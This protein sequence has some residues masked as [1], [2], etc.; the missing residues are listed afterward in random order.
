MK[1]ITKL[2]TVPAAFEDIGRKVNELV[3]AAKPIKAGKGIKVVETEQDV[4]VSANGTE[5]AVNDL[6]AA[7]I[8]AGRTFY[9]YGL[10]SADLT[11]TAGA[12]NSVVYAGG[13]LSAPSNGHRVYIDATISGTTVTAV[14]VANAAT[15]PADTSTHVYTLLATVSVASSIA[16]PTPVAWNYSQLQ[17]CAGQ[18]LWGGF[19]A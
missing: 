5:P 19:G 1:T 8:I 16:T 14:T 18:G 11:V 17:I 3:D 4:T 7:A 12:I 6:I 10:A 15:V 9:V 2:V 13:T